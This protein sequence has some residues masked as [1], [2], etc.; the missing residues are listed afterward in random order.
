V[1][2]ESHL[3]NQAELHLMLSFRFL[4]DDGGSTYCIN[5]FVYLVVQL[6]ETLIR[7]RC[8]R[9]SDESASEALAVP[10]LLAH[11]S[12]LLMEHKLNQNDPPVGK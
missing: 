4:I 5:C 6:L 2:R 10:E 11:C 12:Y 1:P 7:S 8:L 9:L 3:K